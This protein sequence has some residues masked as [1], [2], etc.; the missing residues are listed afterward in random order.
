MPGRPAPGTQCRPPTP[1]RPGQGRLEVEP[2]GPRRLAGNRLRRRRRRPAPP[3]A[4]ISAG[5]GPR[6]IQEVVQLAG[7]RPGAR[8]DVSACPARADPGRAAP[9]APPPPVPGRTAPPAPAPGRATPPAPVPGRA[10]PPAPVPGA[11]R[12]RA[13]AGRAAPPAPR[14]RAAPPA[15]RAGSCGSA[16]IEGERPAAADLAPP[17]PPP[18]APHHRLPAPHRHRHQPPPPRAKI[19]SCTKRRAAPTRTKRVVARF[20]S[21]PRFVLMSVF[22]RERSGNA[23]QRYSRTIKTSSMFGSSSPPTVRS[24]VCQVNEF[25]SICLMTL[26][27]EAFRPS[28]R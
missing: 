4:P 17:A 1:G 3:P 22:R 19:S 10:T 13:R 16:P 15:G 25:S 7:R 11:R 28:A 20:M 6:H 14:L 24:V 23:G 5:R 27:I 12:R 9:P 18:A 2:V 8:G 26:V 21:S